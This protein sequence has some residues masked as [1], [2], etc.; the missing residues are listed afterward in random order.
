MNS[1]CL[2]LA[3]QIG[4]HSCLANGERNSPWVG[5]SM[6]LKNMV[7]L[8]RGSLFPPDSNDYTS[9]LGTSRRSAA[10]ITL[11]PAPLNSLNFNPV[12][13]FYN[14]IQFIVTKSIKCDACIKIIKCWSLFAFQKVFSLSFFFNWTILTAFDFRCF[15]NHFWRILHNQQAKNYTFRNWELRVSV[16]LVQMT[17]ANTKYCDKAKY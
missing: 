17:V 8:L 16:I 12:N 5:D 2:I 1:F 10:N 14:T 7:N 13:S 6:L 4:H 11:L 15:R 3:V 9:Q